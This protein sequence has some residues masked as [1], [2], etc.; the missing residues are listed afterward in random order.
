MKRQH[1]EE[2][3]RLIGDLRPD[4]TPVRYEQLLADMAALC[5]KV[6]PAF[7]EERFREAA[8]AASWQKA[9]RHG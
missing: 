1:L 6:N 9:F 2:L 7:S 3:A 5:S 8:Q 4:L